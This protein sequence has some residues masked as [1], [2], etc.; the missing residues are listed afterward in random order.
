MAVFTVPATTPEF[1]KVARLLTR[2]KEIVCLDHASYVK[3]L[4]VGQNMA[5]RGRQVKAK[6]T[7]GF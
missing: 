3:L 2:E 4:L 5:L 7:K 6:I 1:R